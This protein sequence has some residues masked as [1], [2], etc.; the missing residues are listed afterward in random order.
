MRRGLLP[1]CLL[2]MTVSAVADERAAFRRPDTI[3]FPADAP[4]NPLVATPGKMLFFDPRLSGAQNMSCASCHNPFFGW[5]TPVE[6]AVGAANMPLGRHAPTV[7]NAAWVSPFYWDGRAEDLEAQAAGP[8]TA[9]VEMNTDLDEVVARLSAVPAYAMQFERAFP[10]VGLSRETILTAIATY[11]RTIVSGSTPFD[12]W[13]EGDETA[14]SAQAKNGFGPFVGKDNCAACHTGWNFT[15][16][17]FHDI[18]LDTED[19]GREGATGDAADRY[20]FKTPGLREIANRAP[21]GHAGQMHNLEAVIQHYVGGGLDR[22]TLS[23]KMRPI[24][25]NEA[26]IG[27]L[28]AFLET[29]SAPDSSVP[30]PVLPTQ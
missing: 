3:P 22:P 6:T 25:L 8:I 21:Y 4:Y 24:E 7:I 9:D 16:N 18:G 1:V 13:V 10:G 2:A 14:I 29:L 12:R 15:D 20:A 27:V 23:P 5:E 30:S 28:V 19:V 11:E 17:Q 26:E